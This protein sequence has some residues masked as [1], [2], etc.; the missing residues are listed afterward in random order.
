M[1]E[2]KYRSFW[3]TKDDNECYTLKAGKGEECPVFIGWLAGFKC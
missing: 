3:N 2:V 1:W